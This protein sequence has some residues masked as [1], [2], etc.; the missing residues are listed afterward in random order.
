MAKSALLPSEAMLPS[1]DMLLIQHIYNQLKKSK[2]GLNANYIPELKKVNPNLYAISIFTVKGEV[3]NIG[4]Y[5]TEF[6]L[7]SCSKIFT[8]ALALEKYGIAGL[9][10]RIGTH[11]SSEKFNSICTFDTHKSHTLNSFYNGGALATTSLLYEKNK[12]KFEQKIIDNISEFAGRPLHVKH[13]I[14]A[15]EINNAD[16]NLAIAYLLHS[17]NRFYG[18]V[19]A[20]VEVYTKQCSVMVT[21]QDVAQ[22]AATLANQGVQPRTHKKVLAS[23]YVNY[24]LQHMTDHGLYSDKLHLGYPAKSG[25]SGIILMVIPGVMGIGVISPP[26]NKHGNSVKGLKTAKLIAEH[27]V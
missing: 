7:E 11:I 13:K 14:Y 1:E 15:S 25:V 16:H 26:L 21:S 8:L 10:S 18:E 4:D 23:N 6:A 5:T 24:I 12:K 19:E 2:G 9:K 20:T 17:Y 27:L 22:M 3:Y